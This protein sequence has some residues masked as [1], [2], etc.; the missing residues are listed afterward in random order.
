MS[1]L[2]EF[3]SFRTLF[4]QFGM[5]ITHEMYSCFERYAELLC[6]RNE[7][8]N[9]TAIT[10]PEGIAVKHFFDSV[11]PFTMIDVP[12][13]TK[14]IDVGTGAGFPSVPLKI[15]RPDIEIT[16]LDSLNKRVNFLQEVSDELELNAKCVHGRAEETARFIKSGNPYRE[17][18]DMAT[19]R[20]VANLRDLCE[21][22][23]P[24]VKVGGYFVALKGKDGETELEQAE[25]AIKA[26]GGGVKL[27]KGYELPNGDGRHLIVIEK[28]SATAEKYPRNAGQMKKKPL[29]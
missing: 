1:R 18:F 13:G 22:C 14:L 24:F 9:L 27:S 8:V 19:A 4:A 7:Q 26:L 28:I 21:Y 12:H 29:I 17:S 10:D 20:A 6:E 23:L 2:I 25:N 11:Y 16:M 5:E 3:E 15:F